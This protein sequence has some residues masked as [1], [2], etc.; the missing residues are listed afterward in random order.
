MLFV[1]NGTLGTNSL[2]LSLGSEYNTVDR[3]RNGKCTKASVDATKTNAKYVAYLGI[4]KGCTLPAVRACI[5]TSVWPFEELAAGLAGLPGP[6]PDES[7]QLK[8][9]PLFLERQVC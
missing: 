8:S 3:L 6:R 2:A 9:L 5:S 4:T 1:D 7:A